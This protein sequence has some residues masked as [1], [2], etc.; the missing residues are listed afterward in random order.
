MS[1]WEI[2]EEIGK[3]ERGGGMDG[4]TIEH[5]SQHVA[6]IKNYKCINLIIFYIQKNY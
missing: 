4:E 3:N 6:Y 1:C 2:E 5:K